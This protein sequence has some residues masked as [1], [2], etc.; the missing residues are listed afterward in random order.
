MDDVNYFYEKNL[1]EDNKINKKNTAI[2][3][4][5]INRGSYNNF[6]VKEAKL[7]FNENHRFH[8]IS[9]DSDDGDTEISTP[10]KTCFERIFGKVEDGSMRGSI[11]ILTNVSL[12]V[13]VFSM[14]NVFKVLGIVPGTVFCILLSLIGYYTLKLLGRICNNEKVY[15]LSELIKLKFGIYIQV[16]F[17]VTNVIYLGSVMITS[18]LIACKVLGYVIY[19]CGGF[20]SSY[21]TIDSFISDKEMWN[22]WVARFITH[23]VISLCCFLPC[24]VK[25]LTK[26]TWISIFGMIC[27]LYTIIVMVFQSPLFLTFYIK[28]Y[29]DNYPLQPINIINIERGFD[30]Y[31]E[32]FKESVKL[33]YIFTC[34]NGAIPAYKCMD[35][36]DYRRIRKVAKNSTIAI[37]A[38]TITSGIFSYL[39]APVQ[40]PELSIFRDSRWG[41]INSDYMMTLGK[42]TLLG[43]TICSFPALFNSYRVSVFQL[44]FK[45]GV[46]S[47]NE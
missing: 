41:G 5:S 6:S 24:F 33:F 15:D 44:L 35:N 40:T 25:E 31:L 45:R 46:C 17:D 7:S 3:D 2:N 19:D 42:I 16:I 20:A 47:D 9:S 29:K 10:T 22:S 12:G 1:I 18:Q 13:S 38:I 36:K 39:T 37:S 28:N 4:D 11:F 14:G 26:T 32:F 43:S 8:I 34:Q 30:K 21:Q 27:L 23:F